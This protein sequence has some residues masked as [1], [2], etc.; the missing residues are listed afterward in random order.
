MKKMLLFICF[1]FFILSVSACKINFVTNGHNDNG[2]TSENIDENNSNSDGK[3]PVKETTRVSITGYDDVDLMLCEKVNVM[4]KVDKMNNYKSVGKIYL[5]PTKIVDNKDFVIRV[6]I[7]VQRA[8]SN[9]HESLIKNLNKIFANE[10]FENLN[11]E[12]AIIFY[13]SEIDYND[14]PNLNTR[15]EMKLYSVAERKHTHSVTASTQL[16]YADLTDLVLTDEEV[17]S[18]YDAYWNALGTTNPNA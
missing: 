1:F 4:F 2:N 11:Q 8:G 14:A 6:F 3:E 16:D 7:D 13:Y 12:C 9:F 17:N 15:F 5:E 18:I 10:S